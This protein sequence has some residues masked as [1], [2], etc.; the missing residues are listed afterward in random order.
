L[1]GAIASEALAEIEVIVL[2]GVI[3]LVMTQ[4]NLFIKALITMYV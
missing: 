2:E 3:R 1:Y 4:K